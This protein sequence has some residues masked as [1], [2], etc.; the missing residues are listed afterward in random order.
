MSGKQQALQADH[1]SQSNGSIR[2]IIA[3]RGLLFNL[4][5]TELRLRYKNSI[6]GFFWSLL[7]PLLYL[8]VFTLVFQEVLRTQI[9]MFAIFL[10]SGLLIWNFLS[11]SLGNGA[12][13]I[14]GNAS[15]VQKIWFPR[16][17]L[18][19]AS[20]G[21]A[22]VHFFLQ[23]SVLTVALFVFRHAPDWQALLLLP[24]ALLA[25]VVL[26]AAGA[27]S[28]S[29]LNVYYRDVQ[30]LLEVTLLAWF[31]FTPI[32]YN[33][34]LVAERLGTS[35]WLAM[36]NPVTSIVLTFQRALH[37][38]PPG[39]IPDISLWLY[40]RNISIVLTVSTLLFIGSLRLFRRL[41]GQLA[42]KI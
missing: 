2:Q 29:V 11:T 4:T 26:A 28:L 32:V 39:Y 34:N 30:H 24:L 14:I 15:I 21:A 18:P 10:L 33:Y 12:G 42:E 36:L 19:L 1:R 41:D 7:N 22:L 13:S 8:V 9:P 23:A 5:R 37:N 31:W 40:F 17:V 25:I 3:Y 35:S 20:V 27:L 16:E 6:L 38:P